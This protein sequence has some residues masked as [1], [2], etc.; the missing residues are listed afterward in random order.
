MNTIHLQFSKQYFL[1]IGLESKVDTRRNH[2][3]A[4]TSFQNSSITDNRNF[5]HIV[6][7]CRNRIPE[8]GFH[9][10]HIGRSSF[11]RP[12]QLIAIYSIGS[13]QQLS[14][15]LFFLKKRLSQISHISGKPQIRTPQMQHG[16]IQLNFIPVESQSGTRHPHTHRKIRRISP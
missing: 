10:L 3:Q 6:H 2:K 1:Y 8:T 16:R 4:I 7:F 15:Q 14:F 5:I 11:H 12:H 9:L 13:N